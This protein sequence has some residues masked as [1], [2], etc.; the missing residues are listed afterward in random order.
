MPCLS[1]SWAGGGCTWGSCRSWPLPSPPPRPP[2]KGHTTTEAR[3]VIKVLLTT[4]KKFYGQNVPWQNLLQTRSPLEK[5]PL[6]KRP[7]GQKVPWTKKPMDKKSFWKKRPMD[8]TSYGQKVL[9][10]KRPM[11][12]TSY[13][14]NV[15]RT[16]RPTDKTSYGQNVMWTFYGQNFIWTTS[17]GK[18]LFLWLKSH[19]CPKNCLNVGKKSVYIYLRRFSGRFVCAPILGL[20]FLFQRA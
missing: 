14:Q 16:K 18:M 17:S 20:M 7:F 15:L 4:N 10:K 19:H 13:G 3:F 9:L 1:V 5:R 11:D 12:K 2:P 8:K 6:D